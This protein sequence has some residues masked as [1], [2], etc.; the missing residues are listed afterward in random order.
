MTNSPAQ[1][2]HASAPEQPAARRSLLDREH[3]ELYRPRQIKADAVLAPVLATA[4]GD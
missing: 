4:A 1:R 3:D 2:D